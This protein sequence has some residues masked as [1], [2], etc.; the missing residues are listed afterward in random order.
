MAAMTVLLLPLAA[1]L[2][3]S[4][5]LAPIGTDARRSRFRASTA[6]PLYCAPTLPLH[7]AAA[8]SLVQPDDVV[9]EV[10]CQ[11]GET[12]QIL[13]DA[14]HVVGV[15]IS[16]DLRSGASSSYRQFD[17]P[18]A[19]GL[20]SNVALHLLDP[21]DDLLELQAAC[22]GRNVSVLVVDVNQIVGND[23]PLEALALCRQ[24]VR[25]FRPRVVLVKSRALSLL[26]QRL[27]TSDRLAQHGLPM[28]RHSTPLIV[29]AVGVAAY[30]A[31]ALELLQPGWH[32]LEVGC[33][34]G[35]STA[36][37][38]EAAEASG[39]GR[40]VGVDV[41]GSIVKRAEKLHPQHSNL[42]FEVGDAWS[43]LGLQKAC[44]EMRASD[45]D[46][47]G[48]QLLCV[49]VGG[50]SGAHGELDLLALLQQLASAFG[51]S[52]EAIV[53]KSHCL[54]S[55]AMQLRSAAAVARSV[56]NK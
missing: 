1:A 37:L 16:R 3:M 4:T 50:L 20:P 32:V 55:T 49:D 22:A 27:M 9:L 48:P 34:T 53:V 42:Q 41:S 39:G 29:A 56:N 18:A 15:D 52:L 21:R 8:S 45:G 47:A 13:A 5:Q 6:P 33:H 12:T 51:D 2:R 40:V 54:R 35:T 28:H 10:G 11:L 24:L 31:A 7:Q 26:Q 44:R 23:L 38:A 36:L 43:V 30:R 19:A 17:S 25:C 46:A 14:A